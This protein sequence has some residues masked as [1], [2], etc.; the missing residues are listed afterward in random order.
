MGIGIYH[1]G[2][3]INGSE[4]AYGGNALIESTGVYEMTPR[5]HEV[6]TYLRT[7]EMGTLEGGGTDAVY[8]VLS[9]TMRKYK[10]N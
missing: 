4:Y 1:T 3:E 6:F 8:A 5:K 9:K 7:I 2:V 10:A